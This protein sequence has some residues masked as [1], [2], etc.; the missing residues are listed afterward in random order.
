[1]QT[2]AIHMEISQQRGRIMKKNTWAGWLAVWLLGAVL[3]SGCA[4]QAVKTGD[5]VHVDYTLT[6]ADGTVFDTT[7]GR[8]PA[9]F[10]LGEGN[11]IPGFEEALVGMRVG[12]TKTVTI[13]P[14]KAYGQWRPELVMTASRDL[15]P[16]GLE[17]VVGEQLQTTI[18]GT[19]A[20]VTVRDV[21][22]T[23]LTVDA[24][25]VLAGQTLTFDIQLVAIGESRPSTAGPDQ[26][27]LGLAV[28][29]FAA[30]AGLA[31][32]VVLYLRR[33]RRPRSTHVSPARRS[34]GL[35]AEIARLDDDFERGKVA[36][37]AYRK[38]RAQK[39]AR[40]VR[41][42]QRVIAEGGDR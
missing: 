41:L 31:S 10:T 27:G 21:G 3:V 24:N 42:M 17:P 34:E 37:A 33:R 15:L 38:T 12:E 39:K 35:L 14:E 29:A 30:L 23:T 16:E 18:G 22:E 26:T 36:E 5:T 32:G 28:A 4:A 11:L 7:A 9:T 25:P 1:M 2:G 20:L 13:P 40:L 6:L 8:E 19:L